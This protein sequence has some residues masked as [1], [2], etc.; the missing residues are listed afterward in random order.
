MR[1]SAFLSLNQFVRRGLHSSTILFSK[2]KTLEP[3]PIPGTKEHLEPN[4]WAKRLFELHEKRNTKTVKYA[5]AS[6]LHMICRIKPLKGVPYYERALL[7]KFGLGEPVK[8]FHWVVVENIP[9]VNSE[10]NTIKHL[11]R[12]QP[13]IFPQGLPSDADD[14]TQCRLMPDGRF[15]RTRGQNVR[16][17][18]VPD[19][20]NSVSSSTSTA[21]A[22][23]SD[24][25]QIKF[26][27]RYLSGQEQ[28]L[29]G[30]LLC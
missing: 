22:S 18:V 16:A 14:L 8:K 11:I 2:G 10:L 24:D 19:S 20:Q 17:K 9:S 1:R 30:V 4:A 5:D 13:V 25:A 3:K 7:E 21:H 23:L 28:R 26:R 29:K 27:W 6:P 12:I 15:L